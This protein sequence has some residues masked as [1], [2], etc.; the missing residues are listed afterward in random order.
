MLKEFFNTP[1]L[2]CLI[3][4][5]IAFLQVY[6]VVPNI[7]KVVK[8]RKLNDI[9]DQRSSHQAPTPTMAGVAFFFALIFS[10]FLIQ[11]F[12]NQQV[13][14]SMIASTSLIFLV[15]LKDDLV[16][17]RPS[18]KIITEIF[19]IIVLMY[20]T[21]FPVIDFHGF[22]GLNQLPLPVSYL[23]VLIGM[24]GIINSY[25]LIDGIDGLAAIIAIIIFS[26]FGLMFFVAGGLW[27]YVL[28]C[29]SFVGMLGA[30]L[31]YNFSNKNKIFMGDT[32][33]LIIGF[34]IA[35][36]SIKFLEMDALSLAS[37]SFLPE[38]IFY[39]LSAILWIPLFD[40]I[41]IVYVR[42]KNKKSPFYPD[43]NHLH[44]I[45]IDLGFRHHQ[46]AIFLGIINYLSIIS[47]GYLSG[48]LNYK[49]M[50]VIVIIFYT[51]FLVVVE[52][53]KKR[54]ISNLKKK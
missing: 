30:F 45:L 47:I 23:I 21:D 37:F 14:I 9:P 17:V 52:T 41:R 4:F 18:I 32:G 36:C 53:M 6:L 19:S 51:L 46:V 39:I 8:R 43:R 16:T 40:M 7:T 22:L 42:I 49:L 35:I 15:A 1:L 2:T 34:F 29:C 38:N 54:I 48:I 26:S 33:S 12:D 25:N 3:V 5:V 10:L 31:I 13:A 50:L 27:F 20:F 44:H 28:I 24:L 11:K